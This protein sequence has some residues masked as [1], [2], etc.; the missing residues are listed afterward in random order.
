M[1]DSVRPEG[2]RS[3]GRIHPSVT[4]DP[5]KFPTVAPVATYA[6]TPRGA[7]ARGGA[8]PPSGPPAGARTGSSARR[9]GRPA[10]C[11]TYHPL[12]SGSR[13]PDE[14]QVQ[15]TMVQG[16]PAYY[17]VG[18]E[19]PPILFLHGWGL[20]FR[21]YR[22][23]I[24]RL[25]A[26]GHRVYAPCL[27]GMGGTADLPWRATETSDYG[28]WV[29]AFLD[30]MEL[31]DPIFVIGHSFGGGVAINLA[32]AHP[33]RVR[34]L[35]LLN[36]VG[37]A[38]WEEGPLADRPMWD[39]AWQW[40][41]ELLPTPQGIGTLAAMSE[42]MVRNMVTNPWGLLR[43]GQAALTADLRAELADLAARQLPIL[44]LSSDGD[45]IVPD[46][47]FQ[48]LCS[49]MGAEGRIVRG[50]HSWL[51]TSPDVFGEVLGNVL[52][53]QD[54]DRDLTIDADTA[55]EIGRLLARTEVPADLVERLLAE[56]SPLWLMSETAPVLAG[57]LALCHPPLEPG[58]VR[59]V[60]R[61]VEGST[62]IRL[63]VVAEDRPGLL[64]DT[65]AVLASEGQSVTAASAGT[66][67]SSGLAL[68]ALTFDP[69]RVFD[70]DR[71]AGLGDKL[72]A[73]G[74]GR[75]PEP[76]FAAAGRAEVTVNGEVADR[77]VVEVAAVDQ[78][79]LLWAICRWFA[80]HG[81]S[82]ETVSATTVDGEAN[83]GFI[84]VGD[85][86]GDAL[87]AHLSRFGG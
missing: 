21:A 70:P 24:R 59:A 46:A 55:L 12:L 27:P 53:V 42:D 26:K 76:H 11:L 47:S 74:Q 6:T 4:G 45:G 82:I 19:G 71:W 23:A 32:H 40:W 57:D 66:W 86:D 44:A 67:S 81:V 79:G 61:A 58:E 83:D 3:A 87:A 2:R 16:R 25:T 33:G 41:R 84:V 28:S 85:C 65:A 50:S 5:G 56:A 64:A 43:S 48:A 69:G 73:M 60:A 20:G 38:S 78:V 31:T 52:D 72:A 68:H 17:G 63:T 1:T 15:T 77:A 36:S 14:L 51:L 37:G 30:R 13:A 62:A 18:G 10:G 35:V 54:A 75:A 8:E 80:D 49:A 7:S 9:R 29:A 39:W 22:R 34:Y